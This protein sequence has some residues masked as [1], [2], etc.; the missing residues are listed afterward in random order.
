MSGARTPQVARPRSSISGTFGARPPSAT[1]DAAR[2]ATP[3]PRLAQTHGH[4]HGFSASVSSAAAEE[5]EPEGG[6]A[7]P[8]PV[9]VLAARR[10]TLEKGFSG[11][12]IPSGIP[13]RQSGQGV[14]GVGGRRQSSGGAG[15]MLPPASTRGKREERKLSEVGETY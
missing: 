6:L 10:T 12:P 8:T 14:G 1:G 15:E 4:A 3:G 5:E 7:T 13:R 2:N 9:P 11:I